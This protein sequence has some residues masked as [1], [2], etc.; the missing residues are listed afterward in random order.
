MISRTLNKQLATATCFISTVYRTTW[1]S[2]IGGGKKKLI[3]SQTYTILN[4]EMGLHIQADVKLYSGQLNEP[5]LRLKVIP[6]VLYTNT[7]HMHH[8]CSLIH[9]RTAVKVH[10]LAGSANGKMWSQNSTKSNQS[11]GLTSN[12]SMVIETM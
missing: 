2:C 4:I 9:I 12:A 10:N 8:L 7:T 1:P 11:E 3:H 6:C 5:I